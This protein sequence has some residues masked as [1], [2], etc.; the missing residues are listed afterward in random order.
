MLCPV[1]TIFVNLCDYYDKWNVLCT[2][3]Q[4]CHIRAAEVMLRVVPINT[5]TLPHL[6]A[7]GLYSAPMT[8]CLQYLFIETLQR[9][10]EV[11]V[12]V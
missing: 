2:T 6:S 4:H 3:N 7:H 9:T 11:V 1:F 10:I 5:L 8:S 12:V